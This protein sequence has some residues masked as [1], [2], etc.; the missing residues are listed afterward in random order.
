MT[1]DNL[2]APRPARLTPREAK[3]AELLYGSYGD[4][5]YSYFR[6][7]LATEAI[8]KRALTSTLVVA[9]SDAG[10]LRD[11]DQYATRLFALAHAECRKHQLAGAEADTAG[12][13]GAGPGGAGPVG[14]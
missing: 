6:Q 4:R 10:D 14:A 3:T 7:M 11:P 8:A 1:M 9:A 2:P 12:P 5:L 13:G